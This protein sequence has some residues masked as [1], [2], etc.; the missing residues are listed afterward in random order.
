MDQAKNSGPHGA[1][2]SAPGRAQDELARLRRQHAEL[3]LALRELAAKATPGPW[4]AVNWTC[5][6]PTTIKGGADGETVVAETTG[7]GRYAD[8]CAVD[9]AYIAAA[10]PAAVLSL[11]NYITALE[12]RLAPPMQAPIWVGMDF[13]ADVLHVPRETLELIDEAMNHMGDALNEIDAVEEEDEEKYT[14]AFRAI[15][16]LLGRD[17]SGFAIGGEIAAEPRLVGEAA[18]EHR[19]SDACLTYV[20]SAP[21][22][23]PGYGSPAAH[24]QVAC[25]GKPAGCE[26]ACVQRGRW[27]EQQ[28]QAKAAAANAGG[29]SGGKPADWIETKGRRSNRGGRY[30]HVKEK[31]DRTHDCIVDS[32]FTEEEAKQFCAAHPDHEYFK[33]V[34]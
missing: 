14:P 6:A 13:A 21:G 24:L 2:T 8:E 34:D 23:A 11:L 15:A 20:D 29:L 31:D 16:E 26:A 27:L 19:I 12:D 32:F 28:D 3:L 33:W 9:A 5:H 18:S 7:F 4:S 25:C 17:I 22:S 1:P 10:N 30:W